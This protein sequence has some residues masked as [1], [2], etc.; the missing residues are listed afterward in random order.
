MLLTLGRLASKERAK[1]FD[2][3]LD[4]LSDLRRRI[5]DVCY[6]IAGE[7]DYRQTLEQKVD[8]LGLRHNVIF[9]GFVSE[10]EKPDFYRLSDVYVMPSR[11]EGFGFVVLEALACGVPV[12]AS[13]VDGS[14]DAVMDGK[15]GRMVNP[16]Q[17][18]EL[19]AAI[20]DALKD[21]REIPAGLEYFS[22]ENFTRRTHTLLNEMMND[23]RA[24]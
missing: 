13:T 3:V 19:L 7:G 24:A 20:L 14:R 12:V 8:T 5:P 1:G 17:P 16:D 23:R 18:A 9:T 10:H 6:V 4:I 15:L 11:G 21:P 2:E 22:F